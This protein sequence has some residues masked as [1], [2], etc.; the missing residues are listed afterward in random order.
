M[1]SVAWIV[2]CFECMEY[3]VWLFECKNLTTAGENMG[4]NW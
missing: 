2:H 1:L 3:L 4:E